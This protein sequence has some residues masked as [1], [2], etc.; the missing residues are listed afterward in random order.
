M[1]PTN[2]PPGQELTQMGV[3]KT[4]EAAKN[5]QGGVFIK[6]PDGRSIRKSVSAGQ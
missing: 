6:P 2:L 5:G 1:L 4:Q 3:H